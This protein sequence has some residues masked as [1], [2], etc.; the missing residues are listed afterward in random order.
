MFAHTDA[1]AIL[2]NQWQRKK[3]SKEEA[4]AAKIAKLDPDNAKSAKDVMDE[5]AR[6]R[7]REEGEELSDIEG[8]ERERPREG[9]KLSTVHAK[10]QKKDSHFNEFS[11]QS[12]SE[13]SKVS[14]DAARTKGE[15]TK[16]KRERKKAR[17]EAKAIKLRAREVRREP[18]ATLAQSGKVNVI[19]SGASGSDIEDD[20]VEIDMD[21]V[22]MSGITEPVQARAAT[23]ST[24]TPS[25]AP[26]STS[27]DIPVAQSGTSSISSITPSALTLTESS[28]PRCTKPLPTPRVNQDELRARLQQRIDAL[29]AARKASDPDGTPARNRQELMEARRKKE[30]QRKAHKK[31]LRQKA[32][33]EELRQRD[34]ALSRG[35]PLLSPAIRS[36]ASGSYAGPSPLREHDK[37]LSTNFA[38]GRIAFSNGQSMTTSL[39]SILDPHKQKGPQDPYTALE[40]AKKRAERISALGPVKKADIEGKEAWLNAKKRAHGEK[41]RDDSSL[42]RKT[43]RRKEK[44]KKKSEKDW[45]ERIEGVEKGM[46]MRQKKREGNLQKRMEEKGGKG[47]KG[48]K[49]GSKKGKGKPYAKARPGFEGSFRTKVGGGGSGAGGRQ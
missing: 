28:R 8:I 24:A 44:A 47:K 9:L 6:K 32:R 16:V 46:A 35:S 29:R 3:Q 31:E 26:R 19:P 18:G 48:S 4:R 5:T 7:K 45:G 11:A 17:R 49:K 21:R 10:K 22:S 25:P 20:G 39:D 13:G 34:L 33:E 30:E 37:A 23:E 40:A 41:I 27:S 38:F 12:K 14:V 36:P 2:Q 43:L 1:L 42:L 15:K